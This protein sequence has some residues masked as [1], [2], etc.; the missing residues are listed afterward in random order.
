MKLDIEYVCFSFN[1][2]TLLTNL[3][4]SIERCHPTAKITIFDD[5]STEKYTLEVLSRLAEK[6]NTRIISAT[7]D[8]LAKQRMGGLHKNMESYLESHVRSEYV[9]YVQ[10][11]TQMVRS[12]TDHDVRYI[13]EFFS[14]FARAGF[15]DPIFHRGRLKRNRDSKR[16]GINNEFGAWFRSPEEVYSGFS[17]ISIFKPSRL[18]A[19]GFS[20]QKSELPTS[21]FAFKNFGPMAHMSIP[22]L[23]FMP[24]PPTYRYDTETLAYRL[25]SAQ[26]T[27]CFPIKYLD[28]KEIN[29]LEDCF[30]NRF[31]TVEEFL[32]APSYKNGHPWPVFR[33]QGAPKIY[34][35]LDRFE[36]RVKQYFG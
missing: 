7:N 30:P 2:G 3:V 4:Q 11:D 14:E 28:E 29:K 16:F 23:S 26:R 6:K 36:L 20:F 9:V 1:R 12:I 31:P 35:W 22:F 17:D 18:V 5:Q 21:R 32:C 24:A 27:G 13:N 33:M 25:W 8:T 34:H 10:D 19:S 15:L